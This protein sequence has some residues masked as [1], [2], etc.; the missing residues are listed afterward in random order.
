VRCVCVCMCVC[1]VWVG[2]CVR[3]GVF[4]VVYARATGRH[5]E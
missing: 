3:V 2:G 5:L 1:V 4:A